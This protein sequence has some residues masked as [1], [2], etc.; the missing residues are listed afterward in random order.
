M[1]SLA[2]DATREKALWAQALATRAKRLRQFLSEFS[3]RGLIADAR[4]ELAHC[5]GA[6]LVLRDMG[7]TRSEIKDFIRGGAQAERLLPSM[8]KRLG[9]ALET[10]EPALRYELRQGCARCPSQRRC[11]HWLASAE[12]ENKDYRDFCW[13][14][15]RFDALLDPARRH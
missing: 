4:A 15:E 5:G 8:A 1:K 11:R 14:S 6:E 12:V 9:I 3:R 10:L 13:N 2:S 7:V